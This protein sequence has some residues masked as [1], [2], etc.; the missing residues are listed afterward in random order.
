MKLEI[1]KSKF[2]KKTI[3]FSKKEEMELL[4][5]IKKYDIIKI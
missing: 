3:S 5:N 2:I 4:S 1:E